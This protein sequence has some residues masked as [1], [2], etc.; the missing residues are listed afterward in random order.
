MVRNAKAGGKSRSILNA[1]LEN[2]TN[3]TTTTMH[4]HHQSYS[5]KN[6]DVVFPAVVRMAWLCFA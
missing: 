1:D 2:L 5:N 6:P 3:F 4:R